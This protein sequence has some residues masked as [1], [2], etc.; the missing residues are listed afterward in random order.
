MAKRLTEAIREGE[1]NFEERIED[2][3]KD[4]YSEVK[5][6]EEISEN[7]VREVIEENLSK[8]A[9]PLPEEKIP[10]EETDGSKG[11]EVTDVEEVIEDIIDKIG[12]SEPKNMKGMIE[13]GWLNGSS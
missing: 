10:G 8:L 6:E 12:I 7:E 13:K 9:G 2:V 4:I 3:I 11:P 1:L 5:D